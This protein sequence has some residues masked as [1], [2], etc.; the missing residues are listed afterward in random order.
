M[1]RNTNSRVSGSLTAVILT[2]VL[3]T[4]CDVHGVSDP[5]TLATITVAP[6][7][8]IPA[9]TMQQMIA[10][11]RDAD[12]RIIP[13]TPTWAVTA[14]GGT[15]TEAGMFTAGTEPGP[16]PLTIVARVGVVSGSASISITPGALAFIDIVPGP[17]TVTTTSTQLFAA[18]GRDTWGNVLPFTPT[19]SIV[20]GGGAINQDG[21]FTAGGIAGSYPNTVQASHEGI[22]GFAT[23]TV[24][25]LP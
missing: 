11:G 7:T 19:W 13:I 3:V 12:G 22:R 18:V 20:A 4:A 24:T 6:T 23:V 21:S 5:G 2:A 16:F 17:V 15:I 9:A 14:G 8:M 10:I 1:R 25:I